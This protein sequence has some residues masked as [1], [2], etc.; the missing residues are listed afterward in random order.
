MTEFIRLCNQADEFCH[1]Y[2]KAHGLSG[3]AF[4]ILYSLAAGRKAYTQRELCLEWSYPRQTVNSA[5]KNL[6][7][8]GLVEL[9]FSPGSQKNKQIHLTE[10]GRRVTEEVILP[11]IEADRKAFGA[12]REEECSVLISALKKY[13]H[14]LISGL[15]SFPTE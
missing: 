10:A 13:N 15:G 11:F 6:Q 7:K 8:Q 4:Y 2:A 1:A 5:L 14:N 3:T 12:L 9:R